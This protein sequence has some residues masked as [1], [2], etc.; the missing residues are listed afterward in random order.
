VIGLTGGIA[1]GK[2][3]VAQRLRE[4]GAVVVDADV[5][6]REVVEPGQPAL[7]A[8]VDRFGADVVG[9]DGRLD[10]QRLAAIVFADPEARAAI[11]A[12]T[13]PRIIA[14]STER[15]RDAA[16][17]GAGVVFYEAALLVETGRHQEL[18]GLIVVLA[19]PAVQERRLIDRDGHA[20]ETAR[21]RIAAQLPAEAKRAVAT[22]V[23]END[24]GLAAL[25]RRVDEVVA[26]I[27]AR[28]GPIRP[29]PA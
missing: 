19:S 15:F 12:I 6:A 26:A 8:L 4:R 5:I 1:S 17:A 11:N 18:D 20:P 2:S 14:R 28:F 27:E 7:A 16:A 9:A 24:G 29:V 3:A 22:W 13:H 25:D 21:A 23:I 10:R